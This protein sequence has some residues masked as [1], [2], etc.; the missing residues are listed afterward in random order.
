MIKEQLLIIMCQSFLDFFQDLDI[1]TLNFRSP[2]R[3]VWEH[4][5]MS[6]HSNRA[7]VCKLFM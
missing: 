6:L 2:S 1:S 7:R 4:F 5:G 3:G